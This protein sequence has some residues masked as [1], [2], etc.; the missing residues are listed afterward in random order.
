MEDVQIQEN[1]LR[2]IT[3]A[4]K[5]MEKYSW[6]S[7]DSTVLYV[8]FHNLPSLLPSLT[9]FIHLC[10]VLSHIK[11]YPSAGALWE[12]QRHFLRPQRAAGHGQLGI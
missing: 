4:D 11:S 3:A 2:K 7:L 10:R 6:D 1:W 9:M 5:V 8:I 12:R